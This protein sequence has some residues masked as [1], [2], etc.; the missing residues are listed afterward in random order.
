MTNESDR[1]PA[2]RDEAFQKYLADVE[3]LVERT[4]PGVHDGERALLG[5]LRDLLPSRSINAQHL[6]PADEAWLAALEQ[7]VHARGLSYELITHEGEGDAL[8]LVPAH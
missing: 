7:V 4:A 8:W 3:P 6:T 2:E 1:R 5:P